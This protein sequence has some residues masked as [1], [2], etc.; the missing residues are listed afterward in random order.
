MLICSL[1]HLAG[2]QRTLNIQWLVSSAGIGE[3]WT[4]DLLPSVVLGHNSTGL[5]LHGKGEDT[6]AIGYI[7]RSSRQKTGEHIGHKGKCSLS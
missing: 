6:D 5:L 2:E 1:S 7:T 3:T 4:E